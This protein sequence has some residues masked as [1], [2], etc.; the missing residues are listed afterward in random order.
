MRGRSESDRLAAMLTRELGLVFGT[1][2]GARKS[3]SKLSNTL[4][5]LSLVRVSLV[6]GRHSWRVTTVTLLRDVA[7]ELKLRRGALH[8]YSRVLALVGRLVRGEEKHIELFEELERSALLLLD[9]VGDED[10]D[11]WELLTVAK[12]L[13]H[14]GYLSR[15][16]LPG[17]FFETRE[18]RAALLKLVNRGIHSSGLFNV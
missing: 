6:K 18:R 3:T 15:E 16:S 12:A 17:N 4:L 5:E 2:R 14:L 8:A 13:H 9:E 10:L 11:A 7:S 1:A